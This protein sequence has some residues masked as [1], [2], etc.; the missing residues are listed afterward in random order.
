MNKERHTLIVDMEAIADVVRGWASEAR[1]QMKN[2]RSSSGDRVYMVGLLNSIIAITDELLKP[3]SSRKA[4]DLRPVWFPAQLRLLPS[5]VIDASIGSGAQQ[6]QE[7]FTDKRFISIR[8]AAVQAAAEATAPGTRRMYASVA[9]PPTAVVSIRGAAI[10]GASLG[11]KRPTPA[12]SASAGGGGKSGEITIRGRTGGAAASAPGAAV[13][14]KERL[15]RLM[16]SSAAPLT[17]RSIVAQNAP[18]RLR[19]SA[20]AVEEVDYAPPDEEDSKMVAFRSSAPAPVVPTSPAANAAGRA[21]PTTG[22][23]LLDRLGGGG[24]ELFPGSANASGPGRI[25][26]KGSAAAKKKDAPNAGRE[27]FPR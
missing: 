11:V 3:W 27:L 23:S 16:G 24:K 1:L 14:P 9:A 25:S 18:F 26:L 21:K 12:S 8:G 19:S 2:I 13:D 4:L 22:G 20:A 6:G 15:R 7:N 10:T 17:A 5:T